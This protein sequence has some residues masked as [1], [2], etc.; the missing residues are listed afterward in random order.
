[1]TTLHLL[2]IQGILLCSLTAQVSAVAIDLYK[3]LIA[4][5]RFHPQPWLWESHHGGA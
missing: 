4:A 3:S 5:S 2:D 1:M